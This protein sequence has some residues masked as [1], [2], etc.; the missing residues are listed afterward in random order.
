MDFIN[1]S[2]IR[3]PVDERSQEFI[4]A[5]FAAGEYDRVPSFFVR[6]IPKVQVETVARIRTTVYSI[7]LH[8]LRLDSLLGKLEESALLDRTRVVQAK[9]E[10]MDAESSFRPDMTEYLNQNPT[11]MTWLDR[12]LSLEKRIPPES[13][14][15]GVLNNDVVG[16]LHEYYKEH[17]DA[18]IAL[19]QVYNAI[20]IGGLLIVTMPCSLYIVDNVAVLESIGFDLVE[21]LEIDVEKGTV[22]QIDRETTPKS[23]SRLNHYSFLVFSR[24]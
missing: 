21:G 19:K 23:M 10:T 4:V 6:V 2:T 5:D 15:L 8:A 12:A 7:D 3:E 20:K 14:D 17:S 24:T 18:A 16:Y 22:S 9:L 1:Q 11:E 13:F